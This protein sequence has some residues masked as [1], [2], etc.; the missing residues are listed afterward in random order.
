[1]VDHRQN[2]FACTRKHGI[3]PTMKATITMDSAG[4]VVLPKPLR[5]LLHLQAGT[6]LRAIVVADKIELTPE[7]DD[8]V[9]IVRK[10]RRLVIAGLSK[11]VDA[12]AAIKA[13]RESRDERVARSLGRK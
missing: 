6:K 4:R 9:R 7:P 5:E 12:V 1:M 2:G 10:G 3:I 8:Q 11:G 13:D